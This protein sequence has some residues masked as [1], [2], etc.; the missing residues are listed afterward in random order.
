MA[1]LTKQQHDEA[2]LALLKALG[3]TRLDRVVGFTLTCRVDAVPLLVV[4]YE[5]W[6]EL[7]DKTV[8][9]SAAALAPSVRV[10][11]RAVWG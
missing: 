11:E 1:I 4:E 10:E 9:A 2:C 5:P 3:V 8:L 6:S 7:A